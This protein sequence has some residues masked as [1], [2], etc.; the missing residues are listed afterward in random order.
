M[1]LLPIH[2]MLVHFPIALFLTAWFLN[3]ASS[4]L[5]IEALTQAAWIVY[6]LAAFSSLLTVASGLWEADRLNLHHP[7]VYAHR[8]FALASLGVSWLSLITVLVL[9][10]RRPS[11]IPFVFASA[12]WLSMG[13]V[14]TAGYFGGEMVYKYGIGIK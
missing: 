10:R 5:K 4:F 11:V 6:V 14:L 13:L 3:T 1:E 2:P 8:N 9:R 12:C 7:V